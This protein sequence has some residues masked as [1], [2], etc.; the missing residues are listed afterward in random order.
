VEVSRLNRS[1]VVVRVVSSGTG[2]PA[3]NE[4]I[5]GNNPSYNSANEPGK[6]TLQASA[7]SSINS[8][9]VYYDYEWVYATIP[10]NN[11]QAGDPVDFYFHINFTAPSEGVVIKITNDHPE[12][13]DLPSQVVIPAGKRDLIQRFNTAPNSEA[14]YVHLTLSTYDH[15]TDAYV[16]IDGNIIG[17]ATLKPSPIPG[18]VTAKFTV[19]LSEPAP[20][21]GVVVNLLQ[22]SN[23]YIMP[24]KITVPE[25]STE[26]TAAL[27]TKHQTAALRC[28]LPK[29]AA[30]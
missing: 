22:G 24:G 16:Y 14:T 25:G 28:I 6:L 3:Q 20:A 8:V 4:Y 1:S 17:G 7:G 13:I 18:G 21:N 27:Q 26:A 29:P 15:P 30:R 2:S 23:D 11:L 10:Q 19:H 12:A 9:A 5:S